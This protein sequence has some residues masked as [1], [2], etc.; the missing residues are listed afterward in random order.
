MNQWQQMQQIS[1]Q[2]YLYQYI[3]YNCIR[4][5]FKTPTFCQHVNPVTMQSEKRD[6][7]NNGLVLSP[8][9]CVHCNLL[10]CKVA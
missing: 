3:M 10:K 7:Y 8:S 2:L 9:Q 1:G 4:S 5:I 6:A